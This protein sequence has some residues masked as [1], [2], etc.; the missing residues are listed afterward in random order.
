MVLFWILEA[1]KSLLFIS[2]PINNEN[3][4]FQILWICQSKIHNP[5]KFCSEVLRNNQVMKEKR[6]LE[7]SWW[8]KWS[9][10]LMNMSNYFEPDPF[11]NHHSYGLRSRTANLPTRI[12]CRTKYAE[13]SIQIHGSKFWSKI[14]ENIQTSISLS[15]FKRSYK[16]Y[17]I[18]SSSIDDD[19][20]SF[21]TL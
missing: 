4:I 18:D 21:Y 1:K 2:C 12:V 8:N 7:I 5:R 13:K 15:I 17:L 6:F 9:H 14:P 19:D 16:K 11:V 20:D 3:E 10:R